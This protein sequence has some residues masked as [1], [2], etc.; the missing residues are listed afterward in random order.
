MSESVP[1]PSAAHPAAP[2]DFIRELVRADLASGRHQEIVTRF[3]PEP[4]GYLH[5][6]HAKSICLNFG[7]A[8]ETGGRCHL[9]MD[10]TNPAKEEVE[11]VESILA[12]VHWLIAGWADSVL[13][14]KITGHTAVPSGSGI[15]FQIQSV[16]YGSRADL[17]PFYASDYF[18]AL[19]E[20]A[21]QLIRQGKAYICDLSPEETEQYRGSPDRPG[22]NS[23]WRD[24]TVEENLDLFTRMRAGEFP[25]SA[26]TLRAK[27]DMSSPNIWMRDP[28]IYRIRHTE[29]H[30]TGN[31]W[32]I[33]PMYDFAHCLS[34]YIEG[35]THS[36][37]TLEF[38]VHRPLYDW[39]LENLSLSRP[40]PHQYEFARLNLGYTVMSKRKLLQLVREGAVSGWDDPRLP[41]LSG[42]RRR[43]V[44]AA[45]LRHFA[46]QVGVT[47]YNGITSLAVFEHAV[48]EELNRVAVRRLG[49]LRP[50][51]VILSNLEPGQVIGLEAINN[52]EFPQAGKRP[53]ALTRELWIEQ[54]DFQE[55]PPPKFFRLRPGGEVRLKYACIIR[56]DRLVH[57]AE[58]RVIE[59]HCTAD[60]ESRT[61]GANSARKV[62]GT[63]HWVSAS[64]CIAA[65]FRL[66]DRLFTVEEPDQGEGDFRRHL[67][68]LSLEVVH[69]W[70]EPSL[71]SD[72]LCE[73]VQLERL[74]YFAPDPLDSRP[75]H[76]VLNRTITLKDGWS[77]EASRAS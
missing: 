12:D 9:R 60:L 33:Y 47:K 76:L 10:D 32:C 3:P 53:L 26:R 63:L 65:E 74:G 71:A 68:P 57:D 30:H 51:R 20:F 52:P 54:D 8:L 56:C 59:L 42:L 5:I 23:P 16:P 77:K 44:P 15:D 43:G 14:L 62:K 21:C 40:L 36:I 31:Q 35:I 24:R 27:I 61:G 19:Y 66:Y 45:A 55:N 28:V 22:R 64:H 18:S 7:I 70:A 25:D 46:Q 58:G 6:G 50:L 13:N 72:G 41:T 49:V 4:N 73:A 39:I 75:G 37:C 38:E 17:E 48:R 34:D 1:A 2:T 29:H 67:N 69:G 11:Y